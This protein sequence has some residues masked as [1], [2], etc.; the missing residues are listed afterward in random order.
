MRKE[1]FSLCIKIHV[2]ISYYLLR[3][4]KVLCNS[5]VVVPCDLYY[6]PFQYSTYFVVKVVNDSMFFFVLT[7]YFMYVSVHLDSDKSGE[8]IGHL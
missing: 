3:V 7:A 2:Y 4:I 5:N 8:L 1:C 6:W